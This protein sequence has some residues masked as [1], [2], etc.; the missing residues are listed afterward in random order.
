MNEVLFFITL[1]LNF[2]GILA[3]Y[4]FFG[5]TG[6]YCWVAFATVMANI[7]VVK[8]VDIFAMSLTL[9]NVIYGTTFLVTDILGEKYGAKDARR[10]VYVG[11][12]AMVI[13][14]VF[15]QINLL[16]IPNEADFASEAM[17]TLFSITPRLCIASMMA[18]LFS[19]LLDTYFFEKLRL[20]YKALWIR[21]NFSTLCS[22][23]IDT[24]IFTTIAFVGIFPVKMVFE[25]FVT[26]YLIKILISVCDTPFLYIAK[27]MR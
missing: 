6:L 12:S 9:G 7:E 16:Y 10:A 4:K 17:S 11:F 20:K 27:K 2:T 3:A 22:Q 15:T 5:K 23:F 24:V 26:T 18:Y 21:N 8:S 14:T 25:L 1:L 13:F 19:N